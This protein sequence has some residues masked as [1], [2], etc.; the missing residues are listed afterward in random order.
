[1]S[2]QA[3][4]YKSS[5]KDINYKEF[6]LAELNNLP[7]HNGVYN[8]TI[9]KTSFLMLNIINDDSSVVKHFWRGYHDL[10]ELDLLYKITKDE[11]VFIDV[12]AH[13]GLYTITS[14]KANP[15]NNV[16]CFEPYFM[17]LSRL[18]T[19][20][21]LNGLSNNVSTILGAVS[22]FDGKS[23]FKIDTERSYMS[24]GG[25]LSG[26]GQDT[27]VY[28]LDTLFFKKFKKKINVIKIDTEGEDF[29]VLL[30]A[31]DLIREHKPKIIIEAREE[32]KI[33]I[34]NFLKSKSYKL[35]NVNNL[36]N[37]FDLENNKIEN[38]INLYATL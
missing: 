13:T 30:G 1:M 18:I 28:K 14:L 29:K 3:I 24:K 25:K 35:Y 19:N 15:N 10:N 16:I 7:A 26:E 20:L 33:E 37:E 8:F 27:N 21:R 34:T 22:N 31:E 11:G 2:K 5:H 23:K 32:N 9:S 4:E 12:G 6:S 38:V 36:N 17:N